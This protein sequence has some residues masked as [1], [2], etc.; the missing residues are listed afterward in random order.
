MIGQQQLNQINS[1]QVQVDSLKNQLLQKEE[2]IAFLKNQY[3]HRKT[4]INITTI[5]RIVR[6]LLKSIKQK[7]PKLAA[8]LQQ[9]DNEKDSSKKVEQFALFMEDYSNSNASSVNRVCE[10]LF[11]H[12]KLI[13]QVASGQYQTF[14]ISS[15]K[16]LQKL[17]LAQAEKTNQFLSSFSRSND[18]VLPKIS[19]SLNLEFKPRRR[20][21]EISK[22]IK[23][24]NIPYEEMK[25][26]LLQE[27]T[28][29]DALRSYSQ[30][31][32]QTLQQ[33]KHQHQQQ[34]QE[35]LQQ[36]EQLNNIDVEKLRNDIEDELRQQ[37]DHLLAERES[38]I[39][40]DAKR[41]IEAM[42][43]EIERSLRPKI[44][45]ELRQQ[46]TDEL[47][48]NM[49][50]I[51]ARDEQYARNQLEDELR[52]QLENDLRPEIENKLRPEI[53]NQIHQ[54]L[55]EQLQPQIEQQLRDDI[56]NQLYQEVEDEITPKI[57]QRLRNEISHQND[58]QNERDYQIIYEKAKEELIPQITESLRE[59]LI[60]EIQSEVE[61]ELRPV[62]QREI[63]SELIPVLKSELRPV[64]EEEISP[65][66]I[67]K[68]RP[69]LSEEMREEITEEITPQITERLRKQITSELYPQIE[70][71]LYQ[72]I[73]SQVEDDLTRQNEIDLRQKLIWELT[74]QIRKQLTQ[75][76]ENNV[77]SNYQNRLE[78]SKNDIEANLRLEIEDELNS[79]LRREFAVEKR[80][81][82]NQIESE[83]RNDSGFREEIASEIQGSIENRLRSRLTK[84][85]RDQISQERNISISDSNLSSA[86]TAFDVLCES[87]GYQRRK[88][89]FDDFLS[90]V[91]AI[92]KEVLELRKHFSLKTSQ[93]LKPMIDL[94]LQVQH[95]D[96]LHTQ[97][98]ALLVRQ[99][100][101]ISDLR[102][103]TGV[104]S[105]VSW[106]NKVYEIIYGKS[107]EAYD[108][109][110]ELRL[111]IE[112]GVASA[113]AHQTIW[114]QNNNVD[115]ME[116][117][118]RVRKSPMKGAFVY[119]E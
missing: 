85:I 113:V 64:V 93:I 1:L 103:Q 26:L 14:A 76:I 57:E 90:M 69:I 58:D 18:S 12:V 56:Y 107:A 34:L 115:A 94:E 65:V 15:P 82:R 86:S 41:Q 106:A 5:T 83:L 60:P 53:E 43:G 71:E 91:L 28:I 47:N 36:Q 42:K 50:E 13:E 27:I 29:V 21:E 110:P 23:N 10:Q 109:V 38:R 66:L 78:K 95:L 97:T 44:E 77:N 59:E 4:S 31:L 19:D 63:R 114:K 6:N 75:E 40:N 55:M 22:F 81:L 54:Q 3:R 39:Q 7:D 101:I 17:M 88:F 33:Q 105:W 30:D 74:P 52:A 116:S 117:P 102:K 35:Q 80:N 25:T 37:Y 2:E 98:R 112:E 8:R 51:R 118:P 67:S 20:Y 70:D 89:T 96:Q 111:S 32:Q 24:S 72:K 99:S 84:E 87:L 9:I 92:A 48:E 73:K 62:L 11:D 45:E 108:D 49:D 61:N 79:K 16:T 104:A 100:Q 68:L 119:N 46:I